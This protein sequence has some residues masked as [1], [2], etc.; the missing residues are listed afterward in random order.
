MALHIMN[1]GDFWQMYALLSQ[2]FSGLVVCMKYAFGLLKILLKS[3]TQTAKTG[4]S[5]A[6]CTRG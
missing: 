4:D 2:D 6:L 1:S 3:L 5:E